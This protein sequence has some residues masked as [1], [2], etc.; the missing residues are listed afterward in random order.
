MDTQSTH[1]IL[2]Q[3]LHSIEPLMTCI[4]ED[5]VDFCFAARNNDSRLAYSPLSSHSSGA[6]GGVFARAIPGATGL[7]PPART[8]P[9]PVLA[10]HA[11]A[12]CIGKL[13]YLLLRGSL[14]KVM[15][16][17]MNAAANDGLSGWHTAVCALFKVTLH[18]WLMLLPDTTSSVNDNLL[19]KTCS[20]KG[21]G[22]LE[23]DG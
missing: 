18:Y 17:P 21:R 12:L 10:A 2:M 1:K 9:L 23:E 7:T 22:G 11:S 15:Q 16:L 20:V 8:V 4:L 13:L 14:V 19:L 5:H 3:T 6:N